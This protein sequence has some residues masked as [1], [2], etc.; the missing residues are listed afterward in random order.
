MLNSRSLLT[1]TILALAI[2]PLAE[3]ASSTWSGVQAQSVFDNGNPADDNVFSDG[4]PTTTPGL[5]AS[6]RSACIGS[7]GNLCL[8][9]SAWNYDPWWAGTPGTFAAADAQ[10]S[11]LSNRTRIKVWDANDAWHRY[12]A[13]A[14]SIWIDDITYAGV[15]PGL[16]SFEFRLHG[17]WKDYGKVLIKIATRLPTDDPDGPD[18]AYS[19]DAYFNC[20][21]VN[22]CVGSGDSQ[23]DE[24]TPKFL[25]G[26]D[27]DNRNGSVD[28]LVQFSTFFAPGETQTLVVE[29]RAFSSSCCGSEVDAFN[30]VG[31]TRVLLEPGASITAS[32]GTVYPMVA[33]PEPAT[34]T[35][36]LLGLAG[37]ALLRRAPRQALTRQTG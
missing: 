27:A 32:S 35:L 15:T 3:A 30:T 28:K 5:L 2:V 36:W 12:S 14:I 20:Q 10:T 19:G 13:Q 7:P 31:L 4:G 1:A 26:D 18:F 16:A 29:L 25:P 23:F 17:S 9:A 34:A 21:T 11:V 37:L 24:W 22:G 8:L 33:V 6:A